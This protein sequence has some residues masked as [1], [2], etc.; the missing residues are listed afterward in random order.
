[1]KTLRRFLMRLDEEP[2]S[3]ERGLPVLDSL[4]RDVRYGIRALLRS[5]GFA[6]VAVV[7]LALGI[8]ANTTIF[9]VANAVLYRPLPFDDP[10]RLVVIH[11][12]NTKQDSQRLPMLSTIIEWQEQAQSFDRIEGIV[13]YAEANTVSSGEGAAERVRIQFLTPGAFSLLGLNPAH[14]RVFT[15]E[16]AVPERSVIISDGLWRRR[17]AGDVG[18]LG[19]AIRVADRPRPVVGVMPAGVWTVPWMQD[20]DIWTPIDLRVNELTPQTRWLTAYA[21]LRS[22]VTL[23]QAQAEMDGFAR[24]MAEQQPDAYR[25]WTL[26]VEPLGDTYSRGAGTVLYMLLGAAGFVLLIACA[27]VANLLLARGASRQREVGVRLSLGAGRRR[28]FQ[29]LLTESLLLSVI[30]GA[31]G[32]LVGWGGL[33]IFLAMASDRFPRMD[34]VAIDGKV[35]LFTLTI[36]LLTGILFGLAPA[37]RA[38]QLNLVTMLK[39]GGRQATSGSRHRSSRIL[40][41]SEVA[42][43]FVL[44]VGAGLMI[45]SVLRLQQVDVG[46]DP[47]NLLTGRVQ[48]GSSK[49]VEVLPGNMKRVTPQTPLFYRQV[50]ERL[51]AIPGV[52]SAAVASAANPQPFR[53]LGRPDPPLEQQPQA[54][55]QEVGPDYF[56]T[57]GISLLKGRVIDERDRESTQWVAVVNQTLARTIFPDDDPLGKLLHLR[58]GG[59][60]IQA[61]DERPR[62]IVGVV[63]DV[64]SWGPAQR[65]MPAI[66]T[67]DQQHQWVYPSGASSI[68][69]QKRLYVRTSQEPSRTATSLRQAVSEIDRDQAVL[70]VMPEAQRLEKQIGPWRFFRNLYVIF[71][72]LAVALAVVGVYG[73][74]SYSVAERRHEFSIRMALGADRSQVLRQ[75]LGQGVVLSLAGIGIGIAA[76]FGLTRFLSNLLFEVKPQD[77]LTFLVV[78]LVMM[79]VALLSCYV[80]ARRATA[81]DPAN[82]LRT[83]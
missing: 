81:V 32:V 58:F 3:E 48:L 50:K 80:P 60:G 29:Q 47:E 31:A 41:V 36:S 68:H 76:G 27:N 23:E 46:Y 70:D 15:P 38:T 82:V 56:E 20:V 28:L 72:A 83:E 9:S 45:N 62:V 16:D 55:V 4:V 12:Q 6:L 22:S 37:W 64:T 33:Q 43:A 44:L 77:P 30:G 35:L 67:S 74:M 7:S 11:E 57:L 71:A 13:S 19:Q 53:V 18:V 59:G 8:G 34:E 5:P 39:E 66:Y 26:T 25:D 69:L 78:S 79:T 10:D 65:A 14:G 24:R 54:S 49:Y 1:M 52:R 75:V 21:R 61:D 40:A 42:L 2:L 73:L 51:T 63:P 17:F